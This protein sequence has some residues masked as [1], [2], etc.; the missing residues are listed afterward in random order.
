M[1]GLPDLKIMTLN[2]PSNLNW[3]PEDDTPRL[4][5]GLEAVDAQHAFVARENLIRGKSLNGKTFVIARYYGR[6]GM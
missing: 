2:L 1:N 6:G 3:S 5:G 4:D